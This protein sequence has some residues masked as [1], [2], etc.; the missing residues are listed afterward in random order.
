VTVADTV[1]LAARSLADEAV[2]PF[3]ERLERQAAAIREGIASGAYDNDDYAVGLEMEVYGVDAPPTDL[4]P[5]AAAAADWQPRL[6]ALPPSVFDAGATKELGVHNAEINTEPS[7][8]DDDGLAR[9]AAAIERR[10]AAAQSAARADGLELVL[11]AMWTVPPAAGSHQYL[12]AHE[13]VEGLVVAE[14]MRAD[15]RYCAIDNETLQRSGGTIRF[16]VPGARLTFPTILFESL[17]T[18]IQP[19]LQ[20]PSAEAFPAHYN[21]A[22][23]TLG[24]LLALAANSPFLPGDLY[25]DVDDPAALVEQTHHELRIAA[26]EQ[27]VNASPT[28]KVAVPRDIAHPTDVVD[29]V[30]AD[31]LYAPFLREWIED[32]PRETLADDHWEFDYKR[33]THWRWLRC[34]VGGDPVEGAGDERSLRIEYRPLP[35]QPTVRDVVGLQAL[36]AGLIRGLAAANHPVTRLPWKA[37]KRSFYSAAEN[38]LEADLDWVTAEGQRTEDSEVI[39]A[40]V[41]EFARRGLTGAGVPAADVDH[42]L[43]PIEARVDAGT[44]PSQW[45]KARVS[46]HLA[47]GESLP[48]AITAMQREYVL[49]SRETDTFAAWL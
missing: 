1:A 7:R 6:G 49:R 22:I 46:A 10:F 35:T 37:A 41:F 27:S 38:G 8:F 40:E 33:T 2:A 42:Y 25:D 43:D 4:T 26:F 36:T 28:P 9:Q 23:R 45:K 16:D 44:T 30:L 39:F 19:H 48:A 15:P 21:A 20:V 17:A 32:G 47:E 3:F 12:A 31:D 11:D 24:P 13:T 34:V 14:N 5:A 29:R 18:S